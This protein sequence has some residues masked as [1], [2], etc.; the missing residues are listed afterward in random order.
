MK[1]RK[2]GVQVWPLPTADTVTGAAADEATENKLRLGLR[3]LSEAD[4]TMATLDDVPPETSRLLRAISI[5]Q[6][7]DVAMLEEAIWAINEIRAAAPET[8]NSLLQ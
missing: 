7:M 5:L 6:G 3:M 2:T 1:D 4:V 8:V